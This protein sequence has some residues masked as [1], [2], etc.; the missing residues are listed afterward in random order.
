MSKHIQDISDSWVERQRRLGNTQRAVLY[1]NLP[2]WVNSALHR[3]HVRFILDGMPEEPKTILD[4][5]CGYGRLANEMQLV[6][7]QAEIYGIEVCKPFAEKFQEKFAGCF[8][9]PIQEYR[10][11]RLFDAVVIVTV[12]MYVEPARLGETLL[13]LWD[14]VKPGGSLVVI[15]QYKNVLIRMRSAIG[16]SKLSPTG[17]SGVV[18]FQANELAR[19]LAGLPASSILSTR[20][21]GLM[22][23][24]DWPVLHNGFVVRKQTELSSRVN[25]A[26]R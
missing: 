9:G 12:L 5:G 8:N 6:Y 14:A 4:V 13:R 21:F 7:P 11:D 16:S 26:E 24:I 15:E 1:K 10:P 22:P 25:D 3:K 18:Y 23:L 20:P 2:A 19:L 17:G